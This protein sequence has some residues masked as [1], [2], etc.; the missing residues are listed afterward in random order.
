MVPTPAP[1]SSSPGI[2]RQMPASAR[3]RTS[4]KI[5]PMAVV[6]KPAMISHR[7]GCRRANRPAPAEAARIP[8]V[9]GV[10]I[11]PVWIAL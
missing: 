3:T 8:I 9:A 5:I 2:H 11:R 7:C 4:S 10:S 1:N 6:R